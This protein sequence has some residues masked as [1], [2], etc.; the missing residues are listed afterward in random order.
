MNQTPPRKTEHIQVRVMST[1]LD[2][3][4]RFDPERMEK[5]AR[6]L[7]SDLRGRLDKN[8]GDLPE[9][10]FLSLIL[11]MALEKIYEIDRLKEQLQAVSQEVDD[12]RGWASRSAESRGLSKDSRKD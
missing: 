6:A 9:Q 8:A 3:R 11:L 12:W 2:V 10:G 5:A 1:L 7:D 4:G